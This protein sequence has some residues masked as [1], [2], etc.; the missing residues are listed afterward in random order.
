ML[1]C[2]TVPSIRRCALDKLARRGGW[3]LLIGVDHESNST[4]HVGEDYGGDD[5]SQ[6][7]S[8]E[9][10]KQIELTH[11]AVGRL[12]VL[13]VSMMGDAGRILDTIRS[14]PQWQAPVG[15]LLAIGG[16]MI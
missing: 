15:L 3:V 1:P 8:A 9:A 14:R 11:P 13:L 16:P 4:I 10:P 2:L 12:Q 5:R 6:K 7:I